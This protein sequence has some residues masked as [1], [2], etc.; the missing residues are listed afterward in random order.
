M[1]VLLPDRRSDSAPVRERGR[2]DRR[3]DRH[4]A[5]LLSPLF[6][7]DR[8]LLGGH[9][10]LHA[11]HPPPDSVPLRHPGR[12][13]GRRS[14]PCWAGQ[15]SQLAGRGHSERRPW[16][17][18]I[19]GPHH[20]ARDQRWWV[21]QRRPC[22]SLREPNGAHQPALHLA[23]ALHPVRSDLHLRQDGEEH[24]PRGRPA[25]RHGHHLRLLGDLHLLRRAPEQPGRGRGRC[26][27]HRGKHRGQGGPLRRTPAVPCSTCP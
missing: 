10:P 20:A 5:R 17:R 25:R 23:H 11:L 1:C 19:H 16:P 26:A 15:H 6:P 13:P 4:G 18:R 12:R 9:H 24:S 21:L 3:G 14:D 22:P 2:R 27:L 8:Q 7:H